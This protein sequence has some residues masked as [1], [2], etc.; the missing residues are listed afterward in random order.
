[1]HSACLQVGYLKRLVLGG[2]GP[3]LAEQRRALRPDADHLEVDVPLDVRDRGARALGVLRVQLVH[4]LLDQL[5][6]LQAGR[7]EGAGDLHRPREKPAV[8]GRKAEGR[9]TSV[10]SRGTC[11]VGTEHSLRRS[12]IFG[13]GVHDLSVPVKTIPPAC[14]NEV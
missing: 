4:L 14:G 2:G 13:D 8:G 9:L 5:D 3:R 6:R 1:M 11:I 12:R 7:E 10:V